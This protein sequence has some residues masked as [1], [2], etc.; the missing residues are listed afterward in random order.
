M[1]SALRWISGAAALVL[2]FG[3]V[4]CASPPSNEVLIGILTE[5][6]RADSELALRGAQLAID[7]ANS[8][9]GVHIS[10]RQHY[11]E[12]IHGDSGESPQTAMAAA[13]ELINQEGIHALI[14]SSRSPN[15]IPQAQ[16]ANA[17]RIPFI[18]PASTHPQTTAHKPYVFRATFTDDV[19]GRALARLAYEDLEARTAAVVYDVSNNFSRN[20]ADVFRQT[21]E[22]AG[23]AVVAAEPFTSLS[24]DPDARWK[25]VREQQPDV[26]FLPIY[27][28]EALVQA[29]RARQLGITATFLGAD[30]WT[31]SR[32]VEE[33]AFEGALIAGAWHPDSAAEHP[34]AREFNDLFRRA[35]GKGP[36]DTIMV[37][38]YDAAKLMTAA[39]R[40]AR[41]LDPDAVRRALAGIENFPAATGSVTFRGT[42]GDPK[43]PVCMVRIHQGR[44][45]LYK[46]LSL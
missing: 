43:K 32:L 35:Y 44:V 24:A 10:G 17:A 6:D 18:S 22:E 23:G 1:L 45:E 37:L 7:Q 41:S 14:G 8:A 13:L 11:F 16:A 28:D 38:G 40:Q 42:H 21:F 46:N 27:T 36:S 9:G 4:S 39:I 29:A 31:P 5:T 3:M 34:G 19:Q 12:L 15:A 26:L 25:R 20:L 2:V 30:S 33:P